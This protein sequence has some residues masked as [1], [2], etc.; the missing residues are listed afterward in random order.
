MAIQ[1]LQKSDVYAEKPVFSLPGNDGGS[2]SSVT[3][4]ETRIIRTAIG[5]LALVLGAWGGLVPYIGHALN[6][7]ADGSSL[8]TW[9]LQHGLLYLAPGT[10][11]F[12]GGGV[13]VLSAWVDNVR[14]F[15]VSRVIL[16]FG[17]LLLGL[18][19]IW[20]ILG[21]SIW[22]IYYAGHVF[23]AATPV[24]TF[25]EML[26]YNLS[27]GVIL[28]VLA[29]IVVTWAVRAFRLRADGLTV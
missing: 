24:R 26:V 17:A 14:G 6:F 13:L 25:A 21:P 8:W 1:Q 23:A 12:V 5:V 4:L 27:E 29:G 18:S 22:P 19:G 7:N 2:L 11:A 28:S 9:N 20:F 16:P 10:A 3:R 15:D